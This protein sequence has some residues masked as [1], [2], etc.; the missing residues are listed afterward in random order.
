MTSVLENKT[1]RRGDAT[2]GRGQRPKGTGL[3]AAPGIAGA[4]LDKGTRPEP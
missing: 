3:R 4:L 1:K 2:A